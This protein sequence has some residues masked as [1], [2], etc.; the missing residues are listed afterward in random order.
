MKYKP[1]Y[2]LL[3]IHMLILNMSTASAEIFKWVDNDGNMH[4]TDKPPVNQN[5]ELIELKIN[6]YTAVE[7]VP[8]VERL[9]RKDKL[10]MYSAV[11]CVNCKMAKQY[12]RKNNIPYISYDVESSRIGKRDFKMLRGK[13]V[14]IIIVGD[15]RMNGFTATKFYDFYKKQM[16]KQGNEG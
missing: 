6:T 11:W 15:K 12:F 2:L 7:I 10:V 14:P 3:G 5:T 13:S 4:F 1:F 16:T 8:L 9:G